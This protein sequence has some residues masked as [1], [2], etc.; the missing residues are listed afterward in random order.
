M[1]ALGIFSLLALVAV[2]MTLILSLR[3]RGATAPAKPTGE[4]GCGRC[5]YPARGLPSFT[6]PECGSDLREVGIIR[7]SRDYRRRVLLVGLATLGA[8]VLAAGLIRL[9]RRQSQ[10]TAISATRAVQPL[11]VTP[12]NVQRVNPSQM[13]IQVRPGAP[14]QVTPGHVARPVGSFA[15]EPEDEPADAAPATNDNVDP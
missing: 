6:C 7:P 8:V 1:S 10:L 9:M 5:G 14:V 12:L 4:P 3:L 15:A 13:R 11:A 2:G